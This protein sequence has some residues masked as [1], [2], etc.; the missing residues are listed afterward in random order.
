[1]EIMIVMFGLIYF[2]AGVAL[3]LHGAIRLLRHR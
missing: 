3:S 2:L 1:M